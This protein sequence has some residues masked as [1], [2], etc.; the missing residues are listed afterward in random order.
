MLELTE[1]DSNYNCIPIFKKLSRVREVFLK[2]IHAELLQMKTFRQENILGE[3]MLNRINGRLDT[4]GTK[5]GDLEDI[6]RETIQ[7]ETEKN[8]ENK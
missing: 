1:E 8:N 7:N 4:A 6:T 3:N 5:M 2:K